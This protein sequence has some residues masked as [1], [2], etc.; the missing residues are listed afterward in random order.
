MSDFLLQKVDACH[1]YLVYIYSTNCKL[2]ERKYCNL[3][4]LRTV[5]CSYKTN[6]RFLEPHKGNRYQALE[7][8][9]TVGSS[10]NWAK[11]LP[12][13]L[14]LHVALLSRFKALG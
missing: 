12:E 11:V 3:V 10:Q 1:S 6:K 14:Q 2:I 5:S 9:Q 4:I 7:K 8:T 13:P